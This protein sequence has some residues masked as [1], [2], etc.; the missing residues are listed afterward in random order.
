MTFP[1][2]IGHKNIMIRTDVI[3][4]DLPLLLSKSAMKKANRKFDFSNDTINMLDQKVNIVFT[5]S[6]HYAVISSWK[7]LAKIIRLVSDCNWTRTQNH[8]VCKFVCS[9]DS[10]EHTVKCPV[11]IST[12]NTAQ[13]LDQ[14]GHMVERSFTN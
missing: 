7:I 13:S 10:Q 8:L 12:Q 2:K 1:T 9:C 6:G 14:F 4:T 5:S 3:D 11:Q